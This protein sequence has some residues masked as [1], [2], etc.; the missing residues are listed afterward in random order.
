MSSKKLVLSFL[1]LLV[2][3]LISIS[4]L[5]SFL[6]PPTQSQIGLYQ[7]DL[8][9][10]ASEH[11]D[12]GQGESVWQSILDEN[13][14]AT[15]IAAYEKVI[16]GALPS[17]ASGTPPPRF[18]EL[19]VRLGLLYASQGQVDQAMDLWQQV[20]S[21]GQG[22][23][24]TTTDI[25][26]GLWQNPPKI[27]PDAEPILK[28]NLGGWF[29]YRALEQLYTLQQR[30]A[31]LDGLD[32]QAQDS[33]N[34]ALTRLTLVG[35]LP[36]AGGLVGVILLGFWIYQHLQQWFTRSDIES[37]PWGWLTIWEVMVVWFAAFFAISLVVMPL[38]RQLIP[39]PFFQTT[40]LGQALYALITYLVM[41]VAGF[42]ILV[43]C[44]R[45]FGDRPWKWLQ[46]QQGSRAILWAVQGYFVALPLV[47]A[48]SL[49]SQR[50][51]PNQGGGNPLLEIIL[52]SRDYTTFALLF[53]M[54][55]VLAPIFEEVLFRGFLFSSLV[56]GMVPW[57]AMAL[58]G[59]IFAVAHLNL[60]DVLPL[61]VL[62]TIL[63]Y[64]YW[65]SQNLASVMLL[66][67]FWNTGSFIGLLLLSGGTETGF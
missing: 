33:A 4:L 11:H 67:G 65:R 43:I 46:W 35:V 40:A 29:R 56:Q 53:F 57:Q 28:A 54:V 12:L 51:L 38:V 22:Q 47:L 24:K 18:L 61:T 27:L 49:L 5:G 19:N 48:T 15:A 6:E 13:P 60:A 21:Q 30:V 3:F 26:L 7:T 34:A 44:L 50:L 10:Q 39:V 52:Q 32:R 66:H 14:Q 64:V 59:V 36:L 1:T 31:D 2:G 58:T 20:S 63:S 41:M 8:M 17:D 37:L 16:K 25:L 9:L 45:P 42:S 55:A 23:L 62:G